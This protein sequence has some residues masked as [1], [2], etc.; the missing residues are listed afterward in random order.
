MAEESLEN[1]L[2]SVRTAYIPP[3]AFSFTNRGFPTNSGELLQVCR[4]RA[5]VLQ[6]LTLQLVPSA[7]MRIATALGESI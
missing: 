5:G 2:P 7:E 4:L 6:Y 1:P 3:F